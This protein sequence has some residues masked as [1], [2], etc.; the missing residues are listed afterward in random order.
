MSRPEKGPY[1]PKPEPLDSGRVATTVHYLLGGALLGFGASIAGAVW[2]PQQFAYSW[3]FGFF[4]CFSLAVGAL[5][6]VLLHHAVDADWSVVV[7]RILEN[8]AGLLPWLLPLFL[9]VLLCAPT[10]FK[11]WTLAPGL[12]PVLDA[13]RAYLNIP[14]FLAR[15][16]FYFAA[17][18]TLAH[19]LRRHSIRQDADGAPA[20]TVAMRKA[21]FAG[22][23]LLAVALTFASFDWLMGLDYK[24]FST[25]W[26]V[27]IFAGAAGAAMSLLVLLVTWL[28]ATGHLG[29]VVTHEHYHIMGKLMLAFTVFW[30]YIGFSQYMLIWYANIPEETSYFIRRSIGSWHALIICLTVGRFF[31]PFP[32]LLLQ[33]TKK[34]P[35][36]LCAVAGWIL[37]MQF[38]DLYIVVLPMLHHRGAALHPLDF[39]APLGMLCFLGWLFLKGLAG[40]S[41]FPARDPRLANSIRL[42][43]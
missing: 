30:A 42:T 10:L 35:A 16:A 20:R 33:A 5:F 12:D 25:M 2:A 41:I 28:R 8:V 19:L 31:L 6:W 7:R 27:Y 29:R 39:A 9:P 34:R 18:G 38:L 43:N 21:A 23:P 22:L 13:K 40:A 36:A 14:F 11:W 15:A 4:Y 17:L 24:W 1:Q 37:A 3:L 32:L 26:G